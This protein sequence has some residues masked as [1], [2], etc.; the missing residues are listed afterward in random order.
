M[1]SIHDSGVGEE[2]YSFIA[3]VR[4]N[5]AFRVDYVLKYPKGMTSTMALIANIPLMAL[6]PATLLLI[7]LEIVLVS[8]KS[9]APKWTAKL[10]FSNL[11]IN[12]FWLVLIIVLL[13]NPNLTQPFLTNFLA[14]IFHRTPDDISAQAYMI[15]MGIGFASIATVVIDAFTGFKQLKTEAE[16]E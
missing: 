11:F 7:T 2:T 8:Y 3:L 10:A 5:P 9:S 14:K 1:Y 13:V 4:K 16:R 12:L 6:F 15:I